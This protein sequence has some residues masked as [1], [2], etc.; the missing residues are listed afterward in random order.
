MFPAFSEALVA[1][2]RA[3]FLTRTEAAMRP[4]EA[5][6]VLTSYF[7]RLGVRLPVRA[8]GR[9]LYDADGHSIFVGVPKDGAAI[10]AERA[11]AFAR[12][13]NSMGGYEPAELP[14][15]AE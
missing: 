12:I 8:S 2:T 14:V 15:A 9:S 3:I 4:A 13:I 1:E 11:Q 10:D 5:Q 7:A 6:R